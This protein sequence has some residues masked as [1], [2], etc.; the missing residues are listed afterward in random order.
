MRIKQTNV[1]S[2]AKVQTALA[3]VDTCAS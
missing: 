3:A 2:I 1:L